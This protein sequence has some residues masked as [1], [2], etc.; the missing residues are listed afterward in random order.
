MCGIRGGLVLSGVALWSAAC[1]DDAT[2][3]AG[4]RPLVGGVRGRRDNR[5]RR[6]GGRG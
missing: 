4:G 5:R 3:D 6:R 1:G 2:T